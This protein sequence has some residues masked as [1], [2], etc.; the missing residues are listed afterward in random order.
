MIF[1]ATVAIG[2]YNNN[3]TVTIVIGI[4]G[5]RVLN[6]DGRTGVSAERMR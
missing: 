5:A 4:M 3:N 1:K 6:P 2:Y